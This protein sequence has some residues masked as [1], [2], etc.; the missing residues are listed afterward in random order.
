MAEE[1]RV[2]RPRE[3]HTQ[4][5][6][7]GNRAD[8]RKLEDV[9]EIKLETDAIRT[10]DS[11]SLVKLGNTSLVCG[12]IA[13]LIKNHDETDDDEVF[14]IHVELP[15]ICSTPNANR[16]QNI[17]QLLNRTL[18]N[19]LEDSNCL[20]KQDLCIDKADAHWLVDVEV[21]CLNYD[22]SLLDAALMAILSAL[23]SLTLSSE[24]HDDIKL[25][26]NAIPTC[27]SFAMLADRIICDPNSEEEAVAQSTF[28]V[29]IDATDNRLC[30]INKVGGKSLPN[31]DLCKCI[32]L[33]KNRAKKFKELIDCLKTDET[34]MSIDT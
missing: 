18:N 22:G 23:K 15:P 12:C 20:R 16:S 4:L 26:F 7:K 28:S 14:R 25:Q 2:L 29:V 34:K 24:M 3:F 9:R 32:Q 5:V 30:H 1:F 21:I 33:A 10:A 8:G 27:S 31:S 19:I 6:L 11:S 17:A 13:K